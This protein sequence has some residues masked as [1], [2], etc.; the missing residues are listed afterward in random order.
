MSQKNAVG[1]LAMAPMPGSGGALPCDSSLEVSDIHLDDQPKRK[2]QRVPR[3][4]LHFSD[5]TLEEYSTDEEGEATKNQQP[6]VDPKALRWLP[7]FWYYIV[8][9]SKG[10]LGAADTCGE[11]IAWW[12]GITSP[13]YQYILDEYHR[14]KAEELKEKM[15]EEMLMSSGKEKE[16]VV[17][18]HDPEVGA[19][20]AAAS[21]PRADNL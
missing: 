8:M 13:K 16:P 14:I 20:D 21:E 7:W 4:V 15:E 5:G 17:V 3:R 11:K 12:L 2:R 10:M 9:L 18:V 6:Q 1:P 19:G